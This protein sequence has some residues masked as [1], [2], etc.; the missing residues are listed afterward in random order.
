MR[1]RVRS[2][3][4]C[5]RSSRL[6]REGRA[7]P[8]RKAR[9]RAHRRVVE[10]GATARRPRRSSPSFAKP[11]GCSRIPRTREQICAR[12]GPPGG[13]A[14]L[15]SRV[16]APPLRGTRERDRPGYHPRVGTPLTSFERMRLESSRKWVVA[17][18]E[19]WVTECS[20]GWCGGLHTSSPKHRHKSYPRRSPPRAVRAPLRNGSWP[21]QRFAVR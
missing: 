10:N 18:S 21:E 11:L 9:A 12:E 7:E 3:R 17:P 19:Q 8:S 5:S 6:A 2:S 16:A 1:A 15:A 4:Q 20:K 13:A 14:A